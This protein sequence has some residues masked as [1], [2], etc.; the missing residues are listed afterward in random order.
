[1]AVQIANSFF[2]E[3]GQPFIMPDSLLYD[4]KKLE[5]M[6]MSRIKG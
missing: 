5:Q 4:S 3:M 2:K 1:M 6:N